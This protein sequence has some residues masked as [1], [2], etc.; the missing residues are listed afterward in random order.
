[1]ELNEFIETNEIGL[2]SSTVIDSLKKELGLNEWDISL[3]IVEPDLLKDN[4]EEVLADI[5]SKE[6][7]VR[8]SSDIQTRTQVNKV[9]CH[10]MA[11]IYVERFVKEMP[12]DDH[13]EGILAQKLA[14]EFGWLIYRLWIKNNGHATSI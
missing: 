6:A 3:S 1:M 8:V 11:H 12:L 5:E 10:A 13:W 4:Y 9:I 2:L 14:R 7:E